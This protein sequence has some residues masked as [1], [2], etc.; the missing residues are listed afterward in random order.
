MNHRLPSTVAL[1]A[2]PF[3]LFLSILG[4][5]RKEAA[6]PQAGDTLI[7]GVGGGFSGERQEWRLYPNGDV[8]YRRSTPEH[9]GEARAIFHT[10]PDSVA[11][12]LALLNTVGFDT[13]VL[14]RPGNRTW[15]VER[16]GSTQIPHGVRWS[17][18]VDPLTAQLSALYDS[19]ARFI[20]RNTIT[21][22]R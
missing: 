10:S 13:L 3:G 11:R 12:Y 21:S 1:T 2:L 20:E 15:S 4:G 6:R 9:D 14:D 19:V 17:G 8:W 22:P 7:I 16:R 5:C 18:S